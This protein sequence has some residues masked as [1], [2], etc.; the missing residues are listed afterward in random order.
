[1]YGSVWR[2]HWSIWSRL[3]WIGEALVMKKGRNFVLSCF[4]PWF[5]NFWLL[6]FLSRWNCLLILSWVRSPKGLFK[7]RYITC[8]CN[9]DV[10]LWVCFLKWWGLKMRRRG[11]K[12]LSCNLYGV[13]GEDAEC[14]G[15]EKAGLRK[16]VSP[17]AWFI[18]NI[19]CCM[20]LYVVKRK[21]RVEGKRK[22][23]KWKEKI[24][25]YL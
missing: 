6:V 23:R 4:N 13:K 15:D 20:L 8:I 12:L 5:G 24:F 7:S 11:V 16:G 22:E 9:V 18:L 19:T 17:S 10:R 25:S 3:D 2:G 1:M 14:L 21:Q